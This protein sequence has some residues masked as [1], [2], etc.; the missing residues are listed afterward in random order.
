MVTIEELNI[1]VLL[2]VG[3]AMPILIVFMTQRM[4]SVTKKEENID[5]ELD[6][7]HEKLNI[8]SSS[9]KLFEW[10]LGLIE[11]KIN[12]IGNERKSPV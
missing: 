4:R 2:V 5:E 11:R 12:G 3:I 1:I 8:I 6:Q 9:M 10:R 7:I